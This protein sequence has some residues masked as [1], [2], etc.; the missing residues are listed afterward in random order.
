MKYKVI[1]VESDYEEVV[2]GTCELCM[3]TAYIDCGTLILAD[4]NGIEVYI[5][6]FMSLGWGDYD[7]LY[8]DN[9]VDFS[10]WYK[11]KILNQLLMI[12]FIDLK[13]LLNYIKRDNSPFCLQYSIALADFVIKLSLKSNKGVTLIGLFC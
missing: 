5:P 3:S 4:E 10:A 9:V 13:N 12:N 6:L 7:E 11:N 1:D 2:T 8:I